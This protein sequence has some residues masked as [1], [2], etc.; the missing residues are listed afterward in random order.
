MSRLQHVARLLGVARV[1]TLCKKFVRRGLTVENCLGRYSLADSFLGWQDTAALIE[2][3]I[4]INFSQI[5]SQQRHQFCEKISEVELTR[6]LSSPDLQ[7]V[8]E[9]EVLEAA[10]QPHLLQHP[11]RPPRG[12]GHG[13]EEPH[14]RLVVRSLAS[15]H[16]AAG[17]H[18]VTVV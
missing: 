1:E 15:L 11:R 12:G 3:F 4:Q 2:T 13:V 6:I 17:G 10:L 14:Q 18:E 9:D 16:P 8:S 5:L 7:T